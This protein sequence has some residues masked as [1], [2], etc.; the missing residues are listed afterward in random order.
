[1]TFKYFTV[2]GLRMVP[3][4]PK[5]IRLKQWLFTQGSSRVQPSASHTAI[6]TSISNHMR[7]NH[8]A[9][10]NLPPHSSGIRRNWMDYCRDDASMYSL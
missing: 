5:W 8:P 1:M 2:V 7:C 3:G 9:R 4:P 6:V 10:A